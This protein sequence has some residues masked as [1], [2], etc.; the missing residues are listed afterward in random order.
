MEVEPDLA[1]WVGRLESDTSCL[2]VIGWAMRAGF[3]VEVYGDGPLRIALENLRD[4]IPGG[5][6]ILYGN[7]P[8]AA[9]QFS[10]AAIALPSGFLTLL[11]AEVRGLAC[12]VTADNDLKRDY[13]LMH[14]WEPHLIA[15]VNARPDE[16]RFLW[17]ASAAG[18][19][20]QQTWGQVADTYLRLLETQHEAT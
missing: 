6:A 9:R 15:G 8:D 20:A 11:E 19:A 18:W 16:L 13:W 5:R 2:E 10:R 14:P 3:R 12:F 7:V 4:S 17:S 1:V